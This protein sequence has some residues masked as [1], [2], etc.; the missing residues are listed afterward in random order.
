MVF[1]EIAALL[2]M[3]QN[4]LSSTAGSSNHSNLPNWSGN[5]YDALSKICFAASA[6]KP[7]LLTSTLVFFHTSRLQHSPQRLASRLA[8][9][10]D[11]GK[12]VA[13]IGSGFVV[14]FIH[15]FAHKEDPQ[16]PNFPVGGIL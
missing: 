14:N 16:S 11:Y 4:F 10:F 7:G 1:T 2:Y 5:S 9:V 13:F 6:S 12:C 8:L 3:Q 15:Q